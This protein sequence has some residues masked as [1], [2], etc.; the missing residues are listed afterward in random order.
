MCF[1]TFSYWIGIGDDGDGA[2]IFGGG[3]DHRGAA[4]VDVFDRLVKS[5]VGLGDGLLEGVEVDADEVDGL[6][7]VLLHRGEVSGLSRRARKPP[8]TWGWRVLTRP[9]IISGKPVR[10]EMS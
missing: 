4:D 1:R 9:S 5:A 6:N 3:A 2:V 7:V 10:S 8:W